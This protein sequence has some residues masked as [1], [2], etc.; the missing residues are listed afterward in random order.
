LS[1]ISNEVIRSRRAVRAHGK[2]RIAVR[3]ALI[4]LLEAPVIE[5]NTVGRSVLDS[6]FG[7]QNIPFDNPVI[8]IASNPRL[9]PLIN[10]GAHPRAIVW[11]T[12]LK[13]EQSFR[14]VLDPI[15]TDGQEQLCVYLGK[16]HVFL[17]L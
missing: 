1:Q 11:E 8:D 12:K 16:C 5:S 10:P 13:R 7:E 14:S 17:C 15:S 2:H 3:D 6:T 4:E 9:V